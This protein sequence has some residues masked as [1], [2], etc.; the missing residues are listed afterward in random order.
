[1][2]YIDIKLKIPKYSNQDGMRIEW[3]DNFEISVNK[4]NDEILLKANKNGLISLA[5]ILCNYLRMMSQC[6]TIYI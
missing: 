1:M 4:L 6:T 2:K 3:E 5:K